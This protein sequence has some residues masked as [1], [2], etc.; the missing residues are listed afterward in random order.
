M[1]CLLFVHRRI[2]FPF[3]ADGVCA[4]TLLLTTKAV[5]SRCGT[6][7]THDAFD[8]SD[9][10]VFVVVK[11]AVT[12]GAAAHRDIAGCRGRGD[13]I[14]DGCG[15]GTLL[16]EFRNLSEV[17]LHPQNWCVTSMLESIGDQIEERAAIDV[18]ARILALNLIPEVKLRISLDL[19][20][21]IERQQFRLE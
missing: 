10:R 6:L 9:A 18:D 4:T 13:R 14:P 15:P 16:S 2:I 12:R 19:P 7:S 20:A 5:R 3:S 8:H 1:K 17:G 21:A 11:T